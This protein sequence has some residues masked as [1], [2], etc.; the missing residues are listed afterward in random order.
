MLTEFPFG[1]AADERLGS[2]GLPLPCLAGGRSL[3]ARRFDLFHFVVAF[4]QNAEEA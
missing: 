2:S 3:R 4:S 1:V